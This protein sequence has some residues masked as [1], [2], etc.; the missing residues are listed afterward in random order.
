MQWLNFLKAYCLRSYAG[1]MDGPGT[2]NVKVNP[3]NQ[4]LPLLTGEGSVPN[5]HTGIFLNFAI[6]NDV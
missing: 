1:V 4:G 2:E 3:G 6:P 5:P